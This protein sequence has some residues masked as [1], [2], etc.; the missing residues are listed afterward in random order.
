MI[1]YASI[2]GK[3]QPKLFTSVKNKVLNFSLTTLTP[4]QE[5][6]IANMTS[7]INDRDI[8]IKQISKENRKLKNLIYVDNLE[9]LEFGEAAVPSLI[10]HRNPRA[11][12]SQD[13]PLHLRVHP[14]AGPQVHPQAGHLHHHHG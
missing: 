4:L 12:L 6:V 13:Q 11:A 10:R 3:F 1:N 9:H 7:T 8:V 5:G 2:H 14:Q